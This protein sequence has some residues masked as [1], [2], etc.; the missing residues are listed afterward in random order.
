MDVFP[1]QLSSLSQIS[2]TLEP[3]P[4][5]GPAAAAAGER[6]LGT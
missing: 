2:H 5:A 1:P 3:W 4:R 6:S